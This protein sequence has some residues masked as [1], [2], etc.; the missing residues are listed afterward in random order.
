M[1]TTFCAID[2]ETANPNR[3][4][5]CSFGVVRFSLEGEIRGGDASLVVPPPGIDS[6]NGHQM[7][8]HRISPRKV[9]EANAPDWPTALA[10]IA[11][12]VGDDLLVAHNAPFERSVIRGACAAHGIPDPDWP[13]V[14]TVKM[15]QRMLPQLASHRLPAVAEHLGV[16]LLTHHDALSDAAMAGLVAV[17]L[18]RRSPGCADVSELAAACGQAH[19]LGRPARLL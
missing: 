2:F 16:P 7:R 18:L 13:I 8:I 11:A 10:R 6:F 5:V 9:R 3:G 14:C 17:E 1:E 19:H 4:S 12:V 15:S